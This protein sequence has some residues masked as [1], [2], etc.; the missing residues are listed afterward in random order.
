MGTKYDIE[1]VPPSHRADVE[2]AAEILTGAGCREV[3]LFGSVVTGHITPESDLDFAVRGIPPASFFTVY[4]QLIGGLEHPV[5]LVDLDGGDRF[6]Q[7]LQTEGR[8]HRVV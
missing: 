5:D 2:K 8:L 1:R 7:L 3:Y 4:G 6:V